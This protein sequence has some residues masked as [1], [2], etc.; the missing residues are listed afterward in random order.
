MA[1]FYVDS[2]YVERIYPPTGSLTVN[3]NLDVTDTLTVNGSIIP[4]NVE[5]TRGLINLGG[6]P[7][8]T[9]D[10][11]TNYGL[12]FN[13]RTPPSTSGP[14]IGYLATNDL[15]NG[16]WNGSSSLT[17]TTNNRLDFAAPG[18]SLGLFSLG[19]ASSLNSFIITQNA[20]DSNGGQVGSRFALESSLLGSGLGYS[21]ISRA[22]T[23][24][25]NF[26]PLIITSNSGGY[27]LVQ[28]GDIIEG[29]ITTGFTPVT[30]GTYL[31][32]I[33]LSI[34]PSNRSLC[35]EITSSSWSSISA[36][37]TSQVK[38]N[39]TIF[40][41]S[42]A[43]NGVSNN[44]LFTY[45]DNTLSTIFTITYKYP[46]TSILTVALS[47]L[48][49]TTTSYISLSTAR[50][51]VRVMQANTPSS[52][53]DPVFY[54]IFLYEDITSSGGPFVEKARF[55]P[56]V[57]YSVTFDHSLSVICI[58]DI[59]TIIGGDTLSSLNEQNIT[60]L[61]SSGYFVNYNG[62]KYKVVS[63]AF[64]PIT[65]PTSKALVACKIKGG[66]IYQQQGISIY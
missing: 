7:D 26:R 14:T 47:S 33:R 1:S 20:G 51:R 24:L 46:S 19:I 29:G 25:E 53:T 11:G 12:L 21:M 66:I 42:I 56:K 55:I 41:V 8:S 16:K 39:S 48:P 31:N 38:I 3:G 27:R 2:L 58:S 36:P 18:L 50:W 5:S 57:T 63:S 9:Q 35:H 61:L 37:N 13:Q 52:S 43:D 17:T 30:T 10:Q 34:T 44:A 4:I 23:G 22:G 64:L 60:L 15:S 54:Y 62:D 28:V 49:I 32:S 40:N 6:S 45:Q 65:D 59:D